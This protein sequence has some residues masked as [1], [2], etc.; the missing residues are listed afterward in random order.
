VEGAALNKLVKELGALGNVAVAV[1][2][3]AATFHIAVITP[4]RDRSE[5][6]D[7]ELQLPRPAADGFKRVSASAQTDFFKYFQRH[8]RADELLARLYG[9]ATASGLELKA[10]D[11][12]L[13][14]GTQP[15]TRYQITVPVTG[16][17]TQV[18][19]FLEAALAEI[20]VMSLDQASFR[21]KTANE[22]RIEAELVLT[23]HMGRQ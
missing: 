10:A 1:L 21:R 16:S 7:R 22:G 3:L 17:Y 18:R 2:I 14:A 15:L 13:G 6:L 4:L 5:R 23:L 20:P 11:Y 8:D 12:R 9:I 19:A